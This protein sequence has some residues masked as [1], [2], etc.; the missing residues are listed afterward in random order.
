MGGGTSKKQPP[1]PATK[2]QLANQSVSE[3]PAVHLE[4]N[5]IEEAWLQGNS[6]AQLPSEIGKWNKLVLFYITD[7]QLT[8]IPSIVSNWSELEEVN[9][10]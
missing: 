3:I 6:L 4:C 5:D 8:E 2:I 10:R 9:F 7:N 1:A